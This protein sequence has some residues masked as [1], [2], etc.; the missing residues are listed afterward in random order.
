MCGRFTL[1]TEL[2]L[3]A[4]LY[5]FQPI[6]LPWTP[7][8][9]IAPTQLVAAVRLSADASSRELEMLRW[10]LVPSWAKE[11]PKGRPMINARADTVAEKPTFRAAFKRRRCLILADGFYEWHQ[12]GEIKEPYYIRMRDERPFAMAGLWENWDKGPQPLESATI[13]TT[14]P[15]ELM[16][17]FHHRMPVILDPD[18]AN[19]WL[20]PGIEEP[21]ELLPLLKP[22]PE[23]QMEAY[24]VSSRVNR[25]K[26]DSPQCIEPWKDSE[27]ER[28]FDW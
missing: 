25:V 17:K 6:S 20:D 23:E 5:G 21:E 22:Y 2:K 4:E 28:T 9:N 18:L 15:N 12:D 19:V 14:G 26:D 24:V 11:I 3:L 13:I 1:R 8:Y 16:A 10:G 7:R 27:A